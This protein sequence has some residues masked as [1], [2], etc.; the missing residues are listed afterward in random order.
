[1]DGDVPRWYYFG[2]VP[3][4]ARV[5]I[6]LTWSGQ[7]FL[8]RGGTSRVNRVIASTEVVEGPIESFFWHSE[9]GDKGK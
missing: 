3:G 6:Q 7:V 9:M 4:N 5:A 1:M 8:R 2:F